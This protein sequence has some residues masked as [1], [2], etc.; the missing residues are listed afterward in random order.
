MLASASPRRRELLAQIG[1][2]FEVVAAEVEEVRG[3][4]EAPEDYVRRVSADKAAAVARK[5]GAGRWVLAA[6]TEVVLEGEVLGKPRDFHHFQSMA[7][8]LSGHEHRVLSAVVLCRGDARHEALSISTVEFRE[9][10]ERD[11]TDYWSSGEPRGKAG[12][13][14]IQGLGALFVSRLCGSYSGVMGLPLFETAN[15]LAQAGMPI[16]PRELRQ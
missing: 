3:I 1:V 16:L 7:R 2:E 6:D 12:G 8:R 11:I 10:T 5:A 14:A 15:L 13:Y 4:G 9:L